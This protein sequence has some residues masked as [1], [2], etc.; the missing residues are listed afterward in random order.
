[1]TTAPSTQGTKSPV[2]LADGLAGAAAALAPLALYV[3]T[4]PRTVVLED[5]GLFLMAGEHLGIAHPPG[6]PLHTLICHL[7]MQLPF[8]NPAVLGHLSSAVLGALAC[9]GVYACA[10]VLGASRLPGL[11]AAWLFG[12]SE[13]FWSQAIIAEVYT[14][15][16]A[17]FFAA[18]ALIL[19]G[20]RG[21]QL[22]WPWFGAAALYGFG[23]ANHWPLMV[24]ATPGLALAAAPA[25]ARIRRRLPWLALIAFATASLPYAWMV[26]RSWQEPLISFYGPLEDWDA[27][28]H[29]LSRSGYA[30]VD[31]SAGAGWGDRLAYVWWFIQQLALQLTLPGFALAG[32][33]L[34]RLLRGRLTVPAHG[35]RAVERMAGWGG[36]LALLGNSVL[37]ILLLRFDF[38]AYNVSVFRPYSLV[39]YGIAAVWLALGVQ[40]LL[41]RTE[42]WAFWLRIGGT[43]LAGA[44]MVAYSL[45]ANWP[46][47]DRS[48]SD[49]TE[50]HAR[51][52][53][54]LLP[55]DAV[56]FLFG[57]E[58]VGPLG[59]YHFVLGR[60]P[61]L[62]M[63]S[64][65]GLVF[66]NRL[67]SWRLPRQERQAALRRF[68]ADTDRPVFYLAG[69]DE[70]SPGQGFRYYGFAK[71]V[72]RG[73]PPG[74]LELTVHPAAER[75]FEELLTLRPVDAWE[76]FRRH[77]LLF[78]YG[79]HLGYVALAANAELRERVH[80][81]MRGADGSFFALMGMAEVLLAHGNA[82]HLPLAEDSLRK[83]EGRQ[84]EI[85]SEER[86]ARF[87]YL[88]GFCAHRLGRTAQAK[89]LFE[90]SRALYPH[91]ENAAI[92]A[93]RQLGG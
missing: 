79:R 81:S 32:L 69:D 25:L 61:D 18:F 92:A 29:Y 51:L 16:A 67:F 2:W 47:N 83:A 66:G 45:W 78:N 59:Y 19:H 38:D 85:M 64:T 13:H 42:H 53:F 80:A 87:L 43:A 15:N 34:W 89:A 31:E 40:W 35:E 39:C 63:L 14:L 48:A 70:F 24:L 82:T 71:E 8:G 46:A 90:A 57:D 12:A 11:V 76:R 22:L 58:A 17:L 56:L 72:L 62:T 1:M 91:P 68:V 36:A 10:R 9:V 54:Q 88:R 23:L 49:L 65:Q 75:Y 5:D 93:L 74:T 86:R 77:K 3:A 27:I 30:D 37:L 84:D 73:V 44:G 41:E 33:G 26:L 28:W 6:Y 4:L 52:V 60:R 50:R 55:R 21:R 20:C 7:F